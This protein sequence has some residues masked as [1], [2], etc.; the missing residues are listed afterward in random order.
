MVYDFDK[1]WNYN[2]PA[3]TEMAFLKLLPKALE[4]GTD[5]HLQLLTQIA[6]TQGLQ[7]Q[8]DRAHHTLDEVEK[9]LN[10]QAF[11]QAA[12]RY[13]LERGRVFNSSGNKKDAAPLFEQAWQLASETGNDFYAADA[14]HMLAIVASPEQALEWNLKALHLAENS[15]D[16]RTQ[17]WL[18]SLYNNIGWTYFDMADYE[19]ALALFEK[20]LQWNEKQ[21]HPMEVFIAR[22]SA[23]KT[24][25]LL[26]RT[27]E[28]LHTQ[29]GLLKEMID[30]N[31]EED[32]FVFEELAECLLQL[33]R[34]EQAKKYFAAAYNLL[35]KDIWL[36]KNEPARLSRLQKLG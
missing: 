28:A 18:G 25:R 9:Q 13:L 32:G 2:K 29:T 35:S 30:K 31:M 33:N 15:A 8:F 12:I 4:C 14:L 23:G 21:H 1:L 36:Q 17:K 34:P 27:E 16:T 10:T 6:R 3:D 5:Y 20:C 26:Q 19:K 22:W 11:P 24:L 7:Q